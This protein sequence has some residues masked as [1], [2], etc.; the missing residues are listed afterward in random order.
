MDAQG[1]NRTVSILTIDSQI[2]YKIVADAF[3]KA[4]AEESN[5]GPLYII[6]EIDSPGGHV[7]YAMQMCSAL[8]QTRNCQT[9]AFIKAATKR[10][11]SA[12]ALAGLQ[13]YLYGRRQSSAVRP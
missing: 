1:R 5:K 9:V 4:L 10:A 2:E 11:Y 8:T 7:G 3:E 12:A 6:I 13:S